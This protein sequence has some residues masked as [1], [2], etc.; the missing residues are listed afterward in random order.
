MGRPRS[1]DTYQKPRRA[2]EPHISIAGDTTLE[3]VRRLRDR[4]ITSGLVNRMLLVCTARSK[5]LPEAGRLT[6]AEI[7]ELGNQLRKAL[8]AARKIGLMERDR[9]ARELW[10]KMHRELSADRPGLFGPPR[11]ALRPRWYAWL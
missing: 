7:N 8:E 5:Y 10:A 9:P 3:E 4:V 2:T 1:R 11:A 6:A